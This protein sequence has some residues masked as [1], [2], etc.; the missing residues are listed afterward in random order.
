[1][2]ENK[3]EEAVVSY[4]D[5]VSVAKEFNV[6]HFLTDQISNYKG[7]QSEIGKKTGCLQ[8]TVSKIK[9]GTMQ[10]TADLFLRLIASL[11]WEIKLVKKS[12]LEESDDKLAQ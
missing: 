12:I 11:G 10:P 4:G 5:S 3:T 7:S 8:P 6:R 9:Q 2:E 1:M